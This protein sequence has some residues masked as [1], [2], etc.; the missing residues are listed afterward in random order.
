MWSET[1]ALSELHWENRNDTWNLTFKSWMISWGIT[2]KAGKDRPGIL[3]E[4]GRGKGWRGPCRS[5]LPCVFAVHIVPDF[6][7][8]DKLNYKENMEINCNEY[9]HFHILGWNLQDRTRK[10]GRNLWES[11][12]KWA[13]TSGPGNR[14][15]DNRPTDI[16]KAIC[17]LC[18]SFFEEEPFF[19][20]LSLWQKSTKR[21]Q[22]RQYCYK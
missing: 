7:S 11:N 8:K 14:L 2:W 16:C 17:S 20:D 21:T 22:N 9:W 10:K 4:E 18:P 13:E 12:L 19:V 15:C 3:R 1:I 6:D 5:C